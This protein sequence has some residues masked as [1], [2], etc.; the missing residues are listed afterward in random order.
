[1]KWCVLWRQAKAQIGAAAPKEKKILKLI[2]K[3]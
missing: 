3:E 2:L 1:V